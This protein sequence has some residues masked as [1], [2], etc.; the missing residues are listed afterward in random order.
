M[1]SNQITFVFLGIIGILGWNAWA[2]Q[3]DDKMFDAYKN[4][5]QQICEQMKSFHPDCH[6]E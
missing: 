2:I 5:H 4:R 3:R 6:I 1:K